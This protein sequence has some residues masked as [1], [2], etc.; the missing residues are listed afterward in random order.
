LRHKAMLQPIVSRPH[1]ID[2]STPLWSYRTFSMHFEFE[3]MIRALNAAVG[4][5]DDVLDLA[6][7]ET[8]DLVDS[9]EG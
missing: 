7:Q 2:P 8:P 5:Q 3:Q 6:E 9:P 1:W 4:S